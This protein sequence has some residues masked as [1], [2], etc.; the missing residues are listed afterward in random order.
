MGEFL[1]IF[2]VEI[3]KLNCSQNRHKRITAP[4]SEIFG[5]MF[6]HKCIHDREDGLR[7]TKIYRRF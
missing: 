4:M 3:N 1:L 2:Y 7:F 6:E 5:N